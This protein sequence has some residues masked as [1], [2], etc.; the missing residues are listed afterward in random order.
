[1]L[2]R[3]WPWW[4]TALIALLLYGLT[5]IEAD[6][7]TW[8]QATCMP[9]DCFC[10][11]LRVGWVRQPANSWS[12]LVFV[13]VGLLAI[14]GPKPDASRA[15]TP[16]RDDLMVRGLYGFTALVVGI[17]SWWY[18]A[19]LTF[20]GQWLDVLGM[21]LLPT[22]LIL[23][24]ML[25]VHYLPRRAFL[26]TWFVLNAVLGGGLLVL[27]LWRRPVFGLL[28]GLTLLSELAVRRAGTRNLETRW[29]LS[30][31]V[32][33][34][35]AFGIWWLD[36]N[37]IV[38]DPH[39]LIQGHAAWHMLCAM[40]AWWIWRYYSS[41]RLDSAPSEDGAPAGAPAVG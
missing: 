7:S 35:V 28:L 22:W 29:I 2:L 8:R 17:G 9:A 24:N 30:S 38:C 13:L 4:G 31:L 36:L 32:A 1:M 21:Y 37:R 3:A 19:S 11:A 25:R 33:M 15:S 39:S 16:M 14:R 6:W 20:A 5:G 23:Y 27:P 34:G 10:E 40:A 41:A 26:P 12:N 18:H